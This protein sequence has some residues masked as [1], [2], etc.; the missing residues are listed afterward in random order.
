MSSADHVMAGEALAG[1]A[2]SPRARALTEHLPA[3]CL[4]V[5]LMVSGTV[6]L[7]LG[8]KGGPEVA[9]WLS[10]VGAGFAWWAAP[11]VPEDREQP[12]L[13]ALRRLARYRNT[14]LAVLALL[15]AA[16]A[17][18]APWA[19]AAHT[20]LLL[21][22]LLHVDT[23][24]DVHRPPGRTAVAVAYLASGLVLLAA[25]APTGHS[26]AARLLAALGVAVAAGAV[27]LTLHERRAAG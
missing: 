13:R 10:V 3:R 15:L 14:V 8:T 21:A 22:Y 18:A 1:E 20:A 9:L 16:V 2:V 4:G 27:G 26:S 12:R 17:P 24:S 5:A 25:L 23:F 6:P 11:P 19:A 7:A